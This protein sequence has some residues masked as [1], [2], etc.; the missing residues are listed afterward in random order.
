MAGLLVV[1]STLTSPS[2]TPGLLLIMVILNGGSII[3]KIKMSGDSHRAAIQRG[4]STLG[5]RELKHQG[6]VLPSYSTLDLTYLS[7]HTGLLCMNP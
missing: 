3:T 2:L 6:A 1:N 5:W 7:F 4:V